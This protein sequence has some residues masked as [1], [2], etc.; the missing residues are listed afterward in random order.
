MELNSLDN[1]TKEKILNKFKSINKTIVLIS[2]QKMI[3][4]YV[5]K[6]LKSI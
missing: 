1:N 6:Y 5:M 2:H 4:K 3:L